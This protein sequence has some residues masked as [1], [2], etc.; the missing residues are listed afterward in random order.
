[1]SA[2]SSGQVHK[3]LNGYQAIGIPADLRSFSERNLS[4]GDNKSVYSVLADALKDVD[5]DSVVNTP[6]EL[7]T[8]RNNEYE[9]GSTNA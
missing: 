7:I 8:Q 5:L 6:E 2:L 9:K 1:M 4:L 3:I